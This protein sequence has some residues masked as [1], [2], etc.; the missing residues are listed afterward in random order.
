VAKHL[1]KHLEAK[2]AGHYGIFSGRR[3][4]EIVYP[5]VKSFILSHNAKA[6]TKTG[7]AP[8]V[9]GKAAPQ[10]RAKSATKS[11]AKPAVK[12][13]PKSALKAIAKTVTT[14]AVKKPAPARKTVAKKA[15]AK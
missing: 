11:A 5:E 4:R 14:A 15:A 1:K 9:A 10:A 2:G 13:V 3:W 8:A 6:A 7:V 12:P